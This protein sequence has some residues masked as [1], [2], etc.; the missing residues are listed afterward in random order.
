M[1]AT[2]PSIIP[3]GATT[4]APA[5]AWAMRHARVALERGVVVDG[6]VGVEHAAVAVVGVLVEAEVGH[7]HDVVADLVAQVA[8]GDLHDALGVPGARAPGVLLAGTPNRITAGMPRPAS[9]AHLLAQRLRGVLHDAGHRG[10]RLGLG[11][12]PPARTASATR[13]STLRRVSAT[14]R[15]RAGVV[16]SGGAG[17]EE[18]P[19]PDPTTAPGGP[20]PRRAGRASPR[21]ATPPRRR[22]RY[23]VVMGRHRPRH[24]HRE[25]ASSVGGGQPDHRVLQPHSG[26][27]RGAEAATARRYG[28][29][30]RA[31]GS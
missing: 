15:R 17:A 31:S 20:R 5:S 24:G 11:R 30:G 6:A 10:D 8:Q 26:R 18:R 4:S 7:Q 16:R 12:C 27:R 28:S 13:S 19:P 25:Q 21:P 23:K 2:W 9:S 22:R 3:T 29:E 14:R 1:A